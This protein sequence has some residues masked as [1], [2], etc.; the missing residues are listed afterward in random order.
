MQRDDVLGGLGIFLLAN[1]ALLPLVAPFALMD[2]LG[3]AQHVSNGLALAMLFGAGFKLARYTGE[4]PL[5]VATRFTAFG[6]VLVAVTIALG[7]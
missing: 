6:V 1:A 5:R 3:H 7:G 2:D 4:R